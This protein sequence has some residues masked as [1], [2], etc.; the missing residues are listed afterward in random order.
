MYVAT[1]NVPGYMPVEPGEVFETA[2]EAWTFLEEEYEFHTYYPDPGKWAGPTEGT[3]SWIG[4]DGYAYS[5]EVAEE[6]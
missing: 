1:I 2:E 5:V 4:P 3:G 6:C